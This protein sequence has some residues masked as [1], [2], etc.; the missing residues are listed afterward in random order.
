VDLGI[1]DSA[2]ELSILGADRSNPHWFDA[3]A[4]DLAG[5][6]PY[7][8]RMQFL[9]RGIMGELDGPVSRARR[10]KSGMGSDGPTVTVILAIGP[11]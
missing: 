5:P 6:A 2:F 7:H 1:I 9:W 11:R 10:R 8:H 3:D 4:L